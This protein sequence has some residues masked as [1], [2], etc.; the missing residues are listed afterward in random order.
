M[1]NIGD[2][3]RVKRTNVFHNLGL[4][5]IVDFQV[6]PDRIYYDVFFSDTGEFFGI[7][8]HD[9]ESVSSLSK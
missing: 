1:M 3:V 4:G 7:F 9:L 6:E 2:L 5:I 8:G